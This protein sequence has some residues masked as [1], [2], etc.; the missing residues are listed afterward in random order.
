MHV[1][2]D[3]ARLFETL[4]CVAPI[5]TLYLKRSLRC[6]VK[7]I[8]LRVWTNAYFYCSAHQ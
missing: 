3:Q 5:E 6:F 2:T 1:D 4:L 8:A 7:I